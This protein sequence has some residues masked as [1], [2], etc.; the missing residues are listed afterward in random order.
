[1]LRLAPWV[2][3]V[4]CVTP[5]CWCCRLGPS[6]G[7]LPVVIGGTG[8]PPGSSDSPILD[9]ASFPSMAAVRL[10]ELLSYPATP[11]AAQDLRTV[12]RHEHSIEVSPPK[13]L[14]VFKTVIY[15]FG[16]TAVVN[17]FA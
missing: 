15:F 11:F 3:D 13:T 4:A 9:L 12:L 6:A 7:G 5:C 8:V 17:V 14:T 2:G 1:M 10:P 16:P